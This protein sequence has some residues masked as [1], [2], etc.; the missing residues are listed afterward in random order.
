MLYK[1]HK[2][3]AIYNI[4]L[5][6]TKAGF[7]TFN[8]TSLI[9]T[10]EE[11][12]EKLL[13]KTIEKQTP[14]KQVIKW[15]EIYFANTHTCRP[16]VN[17]NHLHFGMVLTGVGE[18]TIPKCKPL[19]WELCHSLVHR[20]SFSHTNTHACVEPQHYLSPFSTK[21]KTLVKSVYPQHLD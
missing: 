10:K 2:Q 5:N 1:K 13:V 7:I 9:F 14:L 11:P 19:C 18:S 3:N 17:E 21:M 6:N 4:L 12:P 16:A 15:M 8:S 20:F